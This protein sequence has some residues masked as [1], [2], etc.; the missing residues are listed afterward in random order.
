VA[1]FAAALWGCAPGPDSAVTED[2]A[3]LAGDAADVPLRLDHVVDLTHAFDESTVYW[4]TEE[5]FDLQHGDA[6]YTEGGYYYAANRFAAAE[7][8]GTHIDAP[9]HFYEGRQTV[10]EVPLTRLIGD[11]AL[12]DVREAAASD[13]D[14]Q[15]SVDDL[16]RWEVEHGQRLDDRIVLLWTGFGARWPDR[17]SYMGTART[18]A[19]AVAELHFPGLHPNAARWLVENRSIKAIGIDTPS[20]DFGQSTGFESHVTLFE[21]EIPAFENVANLERLPSSFVVVALPMKIG[22]GSGAPLRIVAIARDVP[23]GGR[24]G[25]T[26]VRTEDGGKTRVAAGASGLSPRRPVATYSIVARDPETGEMGVAV[27][28]HWFSVGS[29]VSW[30]EAGVGVVATQS[31]VEPAYGPLGLELMRMGRSAP[32][33]LEA[34]VSTDAGEAVRQVAMIDASGQV[35][36]HTGSRAIYAA[37]HYVGDQ[38]SVQA[39]L[40]EKPTVWEAMARA[41]EAS[42]GDLAERLLVAMEAA[43]AEGGD[44]RG[45]QS[46]ALLVVGPDHSVKPWQD[47]LFD[48]RIEDHPDPVG[49]LRRLVQLQ[50]AYN[51]LQAGDD[52][53]T[54]GEVERAM[55]S[56]SRALDI[57]PDEA[58]NGEAPFWVGITLAASDRVDEAIPYLRRAYALDTRWAELVP[59]LPAAEL[60]PSPAVADQL[61]KR[62]KKAP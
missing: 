17:A 14:Y 24:I 19:D 61:V 15:V 29:I 16:E 45:R 32:E 49:E 55:Q 4:P 23:A 40:M 39:N 56:Y 37:G 34:L 6:G 28:S 10:D 12:I 31:F 30:A 22:G 21:A 47:R 36:A 51:E 5:G 3:R 1:V 41:Y 54:R 48:L 52:W 25:D 9:I 50:R 53:W 62:M 20:I 35:A 44:I 11:G 33:A 38:Y 59:R 2:P 27:Q 26:D 43:E 46:A 18:G 57:V 8:G 42:Q 58:T 13:P 60:L 7:H